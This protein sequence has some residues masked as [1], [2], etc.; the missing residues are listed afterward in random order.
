MLRDWR[1]DASPDVHGAGASILTAVAAARGP[2]EGWIAAVGHGHSARLVAKKATEPAT[3]D[4]RAILDVSRAAAGSACTASPARIRR[5]LAEVEA[6]VAEQQAAR[7]AGVVDIASRAHANAESR[8][9]ALAASAPAHR[10]V[11]VSRLAA[12]ARRAVATSRTAGAERLLTALVQSA[13]AD[14]ASPE[15]WLN[16]LIESS[17][18]RTPNG[19]HEDAEAAR[20]IRAVIIVLPGGT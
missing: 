19:N 12:S 11:A 18:I 9:A 16:R 14:N 8:I 13:D 6:F 17:T 2:F 15:S 4:P 3:T 7:D 20:A 10:R 5:S 1:A